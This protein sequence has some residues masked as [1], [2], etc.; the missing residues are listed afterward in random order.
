MK[1][2]TQTKKTA[3]LVI[4]FI[5]FIL[6]F[7]FFHKKNLNIF[8]TS[9]QNLS[10][11]KRVQVF[12]NVPSF[13]KI[14]LVSNSHDRTIGLSGF[15]SISDDEAMVF[16][17]NYPAK[18][19]FWMKDMKFPIDIIWV[20]EDGKIADMKESAQPQDFPETYT[21]KNNAQYVIELQ[22]GFIKRH[23]LSLGQKVFVDTFILE[24]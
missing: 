12:N 4:I 20:G 1:K 15:E 21:P 5:I 17:F 2:H 6:I 8:N 9:Y 19:S 11:E 3:S 13:K 14:Y 22:S 16:I 10:I 23:N 24:K 7:I 18:Y